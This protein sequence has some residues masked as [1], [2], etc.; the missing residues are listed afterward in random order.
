MKLYSKSA[1]TLSGKYSTPTILELGMALILGIWLIMQGICLLS[2]GVYQESPQGQN[3]RHCEH[4][5]RQTES[6]IED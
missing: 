5:R 6:Y 2:V 3:A 4:I 1:A